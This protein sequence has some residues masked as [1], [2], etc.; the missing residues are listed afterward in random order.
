MRLEYTPELIF[1]NVL[2]SSK[3]SLYFCRVMCII[4]NYG[5]AVEFSLVLETSVRACVAFKSGNNGTVID[6][7]SFCGGK[8]GKSV[9]NIVFSGNLECNMAFGFSVSYYIKMI[10]TLFGYGKVGCRNIGIAVCTAVCYY[11]CLY[12]VC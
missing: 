5:Y 10:C 1:L 7:K 2:C 6:I 9:V 12:S 3:S 11:L 8:C 4:V